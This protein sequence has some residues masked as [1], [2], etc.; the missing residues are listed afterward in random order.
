LIK[1]SLY[2]KL[3]K[4]HMEK[5]EDYKANPYKY[6]NKGILKNAPNDEV[7]QNIIDGRLK[8]LE[9]QIKKQQGELKKII[10]L[11]D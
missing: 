8:A 9:K 11:L 7:R 3:I 4:E 6:D 1:I 10:E 5:L 2:E